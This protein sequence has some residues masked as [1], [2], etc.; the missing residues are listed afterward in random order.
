MMSS[1]MEFVQY[2]ADQLRDMG[3]ISY[4]KMFGEYGLYCDGKFVAIICEDQLFLKVTKAGID[5][6]PELEEN[7]H[8]EGAPASYHL[9]E[10]VDDKEW[11]E[12]L[13]RI[14]WEEL[15][16]PKPKARIK[17]GVE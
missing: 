10:D 11:L 4:R 3:M 5:F 17:E 15:P 9:V 7:P 2:I 1:T 12:Q 13:V 14:T 16:Y 6:Y 8:H